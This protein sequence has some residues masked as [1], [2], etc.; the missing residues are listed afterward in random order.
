M[1]VLNGR[2][3]AGNEGGPLPRRHFLISLLAAGLWR[4]RSALARLQSKRQ[5]SALPIRVS[6]LNHVSFG[7]N[8][9]RSTVQWYGRV[10]GMAVHAFQDYAGGQTVLRIGDGPAYM[11]LSQRNPK[12]IGQTPTRL[13]H[14]CWGV[15]DFN[16][17]HIM[18]ALSEMQAPAQAVLREGKTI[19]GVN[20][21]D[22]DGFPL[23]FNPVN[24]CG[25][26]GYLGDVCDIS[27]QA[28]RQP[29]DPPAIPVRTLNHVRLIVPN[30]QRTLEWYLRLTDMR[31]Q[32]DQEPE[33]ILQVG[34]GPQFVALVSGSGPAAFRPHVGFGVQGFV[35]D[36]IVE[37]LAAHG[38]KARTRLR[39]GV[40]AE[41]LVDAPDG[42]EIQLQDVSYCGG[43]GL[44]GNMCG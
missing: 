39:K 26:G 36:R 6:T 43:R 24:A 15:E 2:S 38:V 25:G 19:N 34:S 44:L 40:T 16:I 4:P 41:I 20:F 12:S 7:C 30:V 31:R 5:D 29:G 9:L 28:A 3:A 35:P 8:D 23:Q 11:A 27:A 21:D 14:F 13:P 32:T 42:I 18:R 37:R 10:F 1:S 22:P 17:D 33:R